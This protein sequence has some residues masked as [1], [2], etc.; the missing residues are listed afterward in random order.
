[1]NNSFISLSFHKTLLLTKP[2][3]V[4][5]HNALSMRQGYQDVALK[6]LSHLKCNDSCLSITFAGDELIKTLNRDYR[7]VDT[8]TDVLSFPAPQSLVFGEDNVDIMKLNDLIKNENG[9]N[10]SLVGN[11]DVDDTKDLGD[12]YISLPYIYRSMK[13]ESDAE[14]RKYLVD[15]RVKQLIVH[16]IL[17]L[18]GYTHGN[19]TDWNS[20]RNKESEILGSLGPA[21]SEYE[22]ALGETISKDKI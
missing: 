8:S 7:G 1:M 16:G 4:R 2:K 13:Q 20:M 11:G 21:L 17:H 5:M 9:K 18:V 22:K 3:L 10:E 14:K 12:I 19:E 15:K 6:S